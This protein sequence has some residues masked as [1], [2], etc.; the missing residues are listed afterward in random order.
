MKG[1][2][3][4]LLLGH[5]ARLQQDVPAH[6]ALH[7]HV[8]LSLGR[9]PNDQWKRR[10][11]RPQE[12]WIDQVRKDNGIPQ[13]I[14]GGVRRVVVTAEQRYGPRWLC[15]N[16]D[17]DDDCRILAKLGKLAYAGCRQFHGQWIII[18]LNA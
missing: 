8:D 1:H 16:D 11:G 7:C 10:P 6:K 9:P 3:S 13:R 2:C 4:I 12:R 14:Y 17:D 15:D 5:V 18:P